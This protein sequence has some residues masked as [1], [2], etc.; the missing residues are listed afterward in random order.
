MGWGFRAFFF[1][2][3]DTLKH[4]PMRVFNGLYYGTDRMPER[5]GKSVRSA[6]VSLHIENKK[7][8]K[9]VQIDTEIFYFDDAG[10]FRMDD[11]RLRLAMALTGP[12]KP[13]TGTVV[14]ITRRLKQKR[15]DD[16]YRWTPT[17][18]DITRIVEAIWPG[19]TGRLS[20]KIARAKGIRKRKPPMTYEAKRALQEC[21]M[22]MW[23]IVRRLGDLKEPSLKALIGEINEKH[24]D[25]PVYKEIWAGVVAAAERQIQIRKALRTGKGKWFVVAEQQ[26]RKDP[27]EDTWDGH[28][29]ERYECEGRADAVKKCRELIAK[30]ADK[31]SE[32]CEVEVR[33][34]PEA[35]WDPQRYWVKD[36]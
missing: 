4:V 17:P 16:V 5:A 11:D 23:E 21:E 12:D 35:D 3:D 34:I 13:A 20:E 14:D 33:M 30:H 18:K 31:F 36:A 28:T 26:T 7:P 32:Y 15:R 25:E 19:H 27:E 29:L 1:E 9:I 6:F 22:P 10:A 2:H 24:G 8:V